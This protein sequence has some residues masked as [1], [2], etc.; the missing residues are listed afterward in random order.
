M[1]F[2]HSAVL[3]RFSLADSQIPH[4]MLT[5]VLNFQGEEN[6]AGK[7]QRH[8]GSSPYCEGPCR[9]VLWLQAPCSPG[10]SQMVAT[11]MWSSAEPPNVA[12]PHPHVLKCNRHWIS[13]TEYESAD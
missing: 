11:A 13:K 4:I 12:H 10:L 6:T 3:T 7:N 2:E 9:R 8:L 1:G 5:V